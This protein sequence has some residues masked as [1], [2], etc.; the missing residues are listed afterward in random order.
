MDHEFKHT[1]YTALAYLQRGAPPSQK[2]R[3]VGR[4]Y[5]HNA[6]DLIVRGKFGYMVG[7]QR[8]KLVSLPLKE[9]KKSPRLVDVD[10]LYDTERLNV[11][12]TLTDAD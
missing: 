1:R 11:K 8:A 4:R 5:G 12:V 3:Q 7:I 9:V 10:R 6:V 2:D